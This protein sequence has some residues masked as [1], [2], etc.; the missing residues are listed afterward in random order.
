MWV[1][2]RATPHVGWAPPVRRLA[3]KILSAQGLR[4]NWSGVRERGR[5]A[6]KCD[7]VRL[8]SLVA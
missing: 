7:K 8:S 1:Q 6:T 3:R 4:P 5:C 2:L